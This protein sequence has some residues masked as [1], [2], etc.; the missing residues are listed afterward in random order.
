[1]RKS[2]DNMVFIYDEHSFKIGMSAGI[3]C[4]DKENHQLSH[5]INSADNACQI[6]KNHGRNQIRIAQNEINEYD[7]HKQQVAWLPK[8][9]KALELNQFTLYV[10][11]IRDIKKEVDYKHYEILIRLVNSDG[12]ITL[13]HLFIPPAE[14]Y[15][16]MPQIDRWVI[17]CAFSNIDKDSYYSINLSGLSASDATLGAYIESL[18]KIHHIDPKKINFEITETAAIQN[19]ENCFTL[20]NYLKNIGFQFSLDDFG[21]GL[22]SF[23]YLKDL[24]ID[25]LKIDGSFVKEIVTDPTSFALVT[26]INEVGHAMGLKTIAEFVENE[27]ILKK[28]QEIGVGYGQGY[29]IHKPEPLLMSG[30]KTGAENIAISNRYLLTDTLKTVV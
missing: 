6:A 26:S 19:I 10:Q 3:S 15:D 30:K 29:Y 14:R 1:M 28:L 5:I 17:E 27:Q 24:N 4:I 23:S 20:I 11:E 2:I 21:S 7:Q 16:L 8:I 22:S 9:N 25:Y 13:P 18:Q 12:S